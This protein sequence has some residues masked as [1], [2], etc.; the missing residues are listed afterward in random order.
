MCPEV[1]TWVNDKTTHF[2]WT[3]NTWAYPVGTADF[4]S[5]VVTIQADP[6]QSAFALRDPQ[7]QR[8]IGYFEIGSID[9]ANHF[10]RLERFLIGPQTAR[11][12]GLG[13]AAVRVIEDQFFEDARFHRF[14]LVV[15]TDNLPAIA[16]YQ[17]AGFQVEGF[18]RE[19]R[20]FGDEWRSVLIMGMLRSE[21][22]ASR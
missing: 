11:G 9:V 1:I 6:D 15:A 17:R 4:E 3:G 12:R 18:L 13:Q 20:S 16:C 19:S 10:G 14:E 22:E 2:H 5:H 21:W 7:S 8:L